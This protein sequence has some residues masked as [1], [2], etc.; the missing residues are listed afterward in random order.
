MLFVEIA[1]LV[2]IGERQNVLNAPLRRRA[3]DSGAIY[4]I[5]VGLAM[6]AFSVAIGAGMTINHPTLRHYFRIAFHFGLFQFMMPIFG[7]WCGI[8]V[9][10][11]V[12][13]YNHWIAMALLTLVGINMIRESYNAQK[14]TIDPSRGRRL[15]ALSLATSMDA[16]A[17][18]FGLGF[19]DVSI[20]SASVMIGITCALFSILGIMLGKKTA[21]YLGRSTERLGGIILIG[22]GIL[23]LLER[24]T[25]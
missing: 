2:P 15:V 24:L 9:G 21:A 5:S 14:G 7:Y 13:G 20:V 22:I 3:L 6:D 10:T 1:D 18:G 12:T 8:L 23:I 4:G 19:T 16:L 17:V 11:W 25:V